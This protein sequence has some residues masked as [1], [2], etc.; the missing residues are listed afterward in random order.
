VEGVQH[1]GWRCRPHQRAPTRQAGKEIRDHD[2]EGPKQRG[3]DHQI[4]AGLAAKRA[5]DHANSPVRTGYSMNPSSPP[6]TY[7]KGHRGNVAVPVE[8]LD[9]RVAQKR[10]VAGAAHRTRLQHVARYERNQRT[11]ASP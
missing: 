8:K 5:V 2:R 1:E 11:P 6:W 7:G 4:L 10:D 9:I 3:R